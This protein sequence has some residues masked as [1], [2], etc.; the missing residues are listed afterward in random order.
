MKGCTKVSPDESSRFY[1]AVS[2]VARNNGNLAVLVN[3]ACVKT[4]SSVLRGHDLGLFNGDLA[5]SHEFKTESNHRAM[6]WT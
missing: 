5:P 2:K 6:K 3:Y 4:V 1:I